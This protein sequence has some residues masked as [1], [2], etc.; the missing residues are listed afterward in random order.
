MLEMY[1]MLQLVRSPLQAMA[2]L[3]MCK[4]LSVATSG[5]LRCC[6]CTGVTTPELD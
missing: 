4:S 5:R 6:S 2:R 1:V 3:L